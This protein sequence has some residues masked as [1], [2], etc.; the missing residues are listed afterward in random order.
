[1]FEF[2]ALSSRCYHRVNLQC[3]TV[4]AAS[5]RRRPSFTVTVTSSEEM[6]RSVA[7]PVA[8]AVCSVSP[9]VA[10]EYPWME[11]HKSESKAK[12]E[13]GSSCHSLKR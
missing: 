8:N 3:P 11:R 5:R 7:I 6:L 2:Q 13:S 10:L 9:K 1:M 12:I 4:M